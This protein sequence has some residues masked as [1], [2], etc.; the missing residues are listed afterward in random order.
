MRTKLLLPLLAVVV[1]VGCSAGEPA[2]LALASQPEG[3]S[4]SID[5]LVM[6]RACASGR[7]AEGRINIE[8]IEL[9]PDEVRLNI[10]VDPLGGGQ[11]CQGNPWTPITLELDEQLGARVVVDGS[12]R[13]PQ[14]LSVIDRR[15][16]DLT[17]D[18]AIDAAL[19]WSPPDTYEMVAEARCFCPGTRYRV[20][21]VDGE[22]VDRGLA[23]GGT[24]TEFQIEP[25]VAPSLEELLDRV[26][27]E[28]DTVAELAL[29]DTGALAFVA[30]DPIPNAVDD[31]IEFSIERLRVDD[32]G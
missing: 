20:T 30:F 32:R 1:L 24:P 14:E 26:R 15:R 8:D 2:D 31:E 19:S 25:A 27:T 7:S 17:I 4:S 11:D 16:G 28:P 12:A 3:D 21:V 29:D 6:E 18:E 5:L 23:D 22:V 10:T 13:P 9:T